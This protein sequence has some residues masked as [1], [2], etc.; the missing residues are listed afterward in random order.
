MLNESVAECER[1]REIDPASLPE[2]SDYSFL[3]FYRGFGEYYKNDL[4]RASKDF[5]R[6]YEIDPT[7]YAKIG[8]ALSESIAHRNA[9]GLEI[10]R[11]LEG[12]MTERGVG[13]PE[14]VY[15]IA[16]AYAVLGDKVSAVRTLRRSI[17]T[18]FFCYPYIVTDPLLNDIR[19]ETEFGR[20]LTMARSRHEA[21]KSNVS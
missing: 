15:K 14:A 21:F 18:G 8:K 5:D 4:E 10:L 1:A 20:I 7:L 13:D 3:L 16:Q 2:V 6:A 17:E 12:K 19:S 9:A 11:R